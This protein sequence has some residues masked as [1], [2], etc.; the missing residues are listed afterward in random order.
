MVLFS[1]RKVVCDCLVLVFLSGI[2]QHVQAQ[3]N[4]SVA[5][6]IQKAV[7]RA[8]QGKTDTGK[9]AYTYTK[10]SV[11]EE[12][13]ATG[14]VKEHSEKVYQVSFKGGT[15]QAK[16]MEVNGRSPSP[17]DLRKQCDNEST[18]H[19]LLGQTKSVAGEN[20]ETFLTPELVARF[21][22]VLAGQGT[23]NGRTAYR[24]AFQPKHPAQPI[25]RVV[26]K[27]LNRISGT[28]WIDT[29]EFEVARADLQLRSEVDLLGGMAG[30]LK[31]LAYTMTR[32]RMME[33]VW[34]N[35]FSS[36]D[37]EG[38]MLLDSL[39]IK[40]KSQTTNFRPLSLN[41]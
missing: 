9:Q 20:R 13:D 34:L 8:Q 28:L 30:R 23:I 17:A 3:G 24:V 33:G 16:L 39:R 11:T 29:E 19:Q 6:I 7:A 41:S 36:G 14:K 31:H 26:D 27:L 37:F 1:C 21:D 2:Q 35:S 12:L 4:L 22:F 10:V 32:T 18:V 5:E 15:N 25:H 38:R 40:T